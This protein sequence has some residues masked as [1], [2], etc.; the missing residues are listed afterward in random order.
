[1]PTNNRGRLDREEEKEYRVLLCAEDGGVPPN[2]GTLQV[3]V[4]VVDANDNAPVFNQSEHLSA[5]VREDTP[6]RT[7]LLKVCWEEGEEGRRR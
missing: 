2:T 5:V 1:M 4:N 3:L 7:V 6:L